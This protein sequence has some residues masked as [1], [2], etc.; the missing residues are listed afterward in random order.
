MQY[1]LANVPC[2]PWVQESML[3]K[4]GSNRNTIGLTC[5]HLKIE[6]KMPKFTTYHILIYH[7][8]LNC[9]LWKWISVRWGS[10]I[11][12]PRSLALDNNLMG[13]QVSYPPIIFNIGELHKS[14]LSQPR[15]LPIYWEA[16]GQY[17]TLQSVSMY[18][19]HLYAIFEKVNR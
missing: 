6:Y 9:V 7:V 13:L 1:S 19:Y 2:A 14:L 17:P 10:Y 18:T 12:T 15:W 8:I 3:I 5:L 11:M 16:R 4:L